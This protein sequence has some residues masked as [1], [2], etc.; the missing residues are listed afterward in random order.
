MEE[1]KTVAEL[2][3]KSE[4]QSPENGEKR[5]DVCPSASTL[6]W[7]IRTTKNSDRMSC[8]EAYRLEIAKHL[9]MRIGTQP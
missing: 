8:D 2:E 3:S 4:G 6:E 7:M 9:S 1:S 5:V